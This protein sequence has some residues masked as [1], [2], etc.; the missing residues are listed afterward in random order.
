V[1]SEMYLWQ[2]DI[3]RVFGQLH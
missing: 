1:T 2:T 3:C